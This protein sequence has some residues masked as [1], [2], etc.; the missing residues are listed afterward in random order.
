MVVRKIKALV[1]DA[2][3]PNWKNQSRGIV[4]RRELHEFRTVFKENFITLIVSAF[5]VVAALSWNDAVKEAVLSFF[6]EKGN[7]I[8]KVYTAVVITIISILATY[9]LSKLKSKN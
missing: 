1:A 7:L 8:V 9:L 5:G 2:T 4:L 3:G 6:P